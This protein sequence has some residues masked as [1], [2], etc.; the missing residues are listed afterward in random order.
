MDYIHEFVIDE[1]NFDTAKLEKAIAEKPELAVLQ[2]I[3]GITVEV[4]GYLTLEDNRFDAPYQEGFVTGGSVDQVAYISHVAWT[5]NDSQ[6]ED[7]ERLMAGEESES[8]KS[9]LNLLR[10]KL[11]TEPK[12]DLTY[13]LLPLLSKDGIAEL[14]EMF[15]KEFGD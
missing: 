14:E 6:F 10:N 9:A 13:N 11:R 2:F 5:I 3:S 7:Y 15:L 12:H 4:E 1:S 8:L